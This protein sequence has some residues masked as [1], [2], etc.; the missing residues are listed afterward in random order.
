MTTPTKR[1]QSLAKE[2]DKIGQKMT[3]GELILNCHAK[4]AKLHIFYGRL[5]YATSE[6]HRVWQWQRAIKQYCPNW[7]AK[8][9]APISPKQPWE[10]Q[11]LYQGVSKKQI[12]LDRAKA[13]IRRVAFE[14]LFCLCRYPDLSYELQPKEASDLD[15]SLGLSLSYRE[16]E[17]AIARVSQLLSQ[18]QA[19]GLDSLSPTLVPVAKKSVSPDSFSGIGQYLNGEYDLWDLASRLQKSITVV[20]RGLMPLIS[21]GAVRLKMMPDLKTP[22]FPEAKPKQQQARAKETLK[23]ERNLI[24][25]IDD[26]PVVAQTLRNIVEPV[27][28]QLIYTADPVKGLAQLAQHKPDLIFLDIEMPNASGYTVCQFLRKAPAF[29]NTPVIV[30]TSRDNVV[31]RSRA[32]L[33]GASEFISKPPEPEQVLQTIEKY[34]GSQAGD[35]GKPTDVGDLKFE[36]ISS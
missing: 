33:V 32:K 23:S 20:T 21:R 7:E 25:C 27:G 29:K 1:L 12:D 24:A 9:I 18:W 19:A 13:V 36:G 4:E 2:L 10:Y 6:F 34:L 15:L 14:I 35:R 31:D 16:L 28:Y 30:L 22:T 8:A 3:S 17:P 5:L 11:L 26:S